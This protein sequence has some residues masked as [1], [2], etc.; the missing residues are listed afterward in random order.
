[1][2]QKIRKGILLFSALL[3]PFTFFFL[4][5]FVIVMSASQGIIN[6]SAVIF[7]LLLLFSLITSRL[8]CGWLC[9]GG[10]VQDYAASANGRRWNG[11][12]KN[13][14]K[15]VIWGVWLSFIIFL[16]VSHRPLSVDFAFQWSVDLQYMIIYAIVMMVILTL[17]LFTGKRGMCHSFCWMAPFMVVGEKLSDFLHIPR[18]RLQAEPDRCTSCGKCTRNCPMSLDVSAMVQAGKMDSA[19]CIS[20]LLCVDGC[21]EHAIHCGI[22]PKQHKR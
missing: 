17:S 3:F 21:P 1:M 2:R 8:Y 11:R 15:Y 22:L 5:P 20:C 16:W 14:I 12:I 13:A 18:F 9:P 4:S 7:G 10:A 19:E 6:G